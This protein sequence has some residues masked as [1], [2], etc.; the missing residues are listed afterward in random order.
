M[1]HNVLSFFIYLA[2]LF[3]EPPFNGSPPKLADRLSWWKSLSKDSGADVLARLAIKLFSVIPSEM[4]DERTASKL[5]AMSTA[6]RNNLSAENLVRC[7]QLNQYW[8]Y[9]YGRQEVKNHVPH[10]VRLEL[11]TSNRQPTDPKRAR[12]PTLDDLLNPIAPTDSD[13]P[14]DFDSLFNLRSNDPF[15]AAEVED[16][17][18][19][20]DD[21]D[22]AAPPL[23]QRVDNMPVLEIETY[24]NLKAPKLIQ[25]F[26]PKQLD[27]RT[28]L[29]PRKPTAAAKS[30]WDPE[31]SKWDASKW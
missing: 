4:C 25:R 10:Q 17:A 11:P 24:I 12:I 21:D 19:G 23:V 26:A 8:R 15:N 27:I 20:E 18:V 22:M 7:A 5:S 16:M 31:S 6:K 14:I 1:V 30:A 28:A 29:S 3:C 13:Q 9:G 2:Y